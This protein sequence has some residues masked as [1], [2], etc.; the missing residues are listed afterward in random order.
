MISVSS[1]KYFLLF[2]T[3]KFAGVA[4]G[5][6]QE[7]VD[8]WWFRQA[9]CDLSVSSG[10]SSHAYTSHV[11]ALY[12][13]TSESAFKSLFIYHHSIV[14]AKHVDKAMLSTQFKYFCW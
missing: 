10:A 12:D 11:T 2:L 9:P 14:H 7:W 3:E 13:T 8:Y 1:T 6:I 4:A 5:Y